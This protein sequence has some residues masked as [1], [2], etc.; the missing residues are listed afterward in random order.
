MLYT[1]QEGRR[2]RAVSLDSCVFWVL[3]TL[4][5]YTAWIACVLCQ[6]LVSSHRA[7]ILLTGRGFEGTDFGHYRRSAR[8]VFLLRR[9]VGAIGHL[10]EAG[11]AEQKKPKASV[12]LKIMP[13]SA[14]GLVEVGGPEDAQTHLEV[15]AWASSVALLFLKANS[16]RQQRALGWLSFLCGNTAV[17]LW[18][19]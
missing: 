15:A 10:K 18:T 13:G 9:E 2:R 11:S 17:L 6:V 16:E 3:R 4:S 5:S 19:G 1:Q 12:S 14:K 8:L 7:S